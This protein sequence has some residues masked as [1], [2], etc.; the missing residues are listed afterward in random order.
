METPPPPDVTPE[1]R[2]RY[3]PYSLPRRWVGDM[4]HAAR[5]VPVIACERVIRV[6][7]M[8]ELR[9]QT[10]KPPSWS[11]LLIKAMGLISVKMPELRRAYLGFPWGRIYEAPYSVASV[12]F[13]RQF[14]G[15]EAT[16]FAPMLHPE[17]S[18]LDKIGGKLQAWKNDPVEAHGALRR[19]VRNA[20]PPRP[21]RRAMW[22]F[23][24][25][26]FGLMRA[27]Y[28][29]TFAVNSVASIGGRMLQ[30]ATPLTQVLYYGAVNRDGE[31]LIQFA[32]DHR[33]Y[34]GITVA[35]ASVKLEE[36]LNNELIAEVQNL[37]AVR[38]AAAPPK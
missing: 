16:F 31:M 36:V 34:D 18:P 38:T 23:G 8:R 22:W 29:G 9:R 28:F 24:L 3:L 17:R 10:P 20:K 6:K 7:A 33:V 21:I 32:F 37:P 14:R 2:G 13:G 12:I 30:F 26:W 15:E 27:R 19:L 5:K 1:D 4:L 35:V 25:N 11:S